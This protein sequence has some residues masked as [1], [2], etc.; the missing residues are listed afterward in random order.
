MDADV[1]KELI[2][3]SEKVEWG[4]GK[5]KDHYAVVSRKGFTEEAKVFADGKKMHLFTLEGMIQ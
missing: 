2:E 1:M 3:R 4:N 5:R